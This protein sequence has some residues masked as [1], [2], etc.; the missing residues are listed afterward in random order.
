MEVVGAAASVIAI[1]QIA[2]SVIKLCKA[3]ITGVQ[4]TPTD[5]RVILIEVGSIKCVLETLDLMRSSANGNSWAELL[6][7]LQGPDGQLC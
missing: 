4:D 5:L 3:Y 1:V 7:T 2:E 6:R